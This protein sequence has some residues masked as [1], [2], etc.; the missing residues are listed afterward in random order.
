MSASVFCPHFF[1]GCVFSSYW[2]IRL[3]WIGLLLCFMNIFYQSMAL[4]LTFLKDLNLVVFKISCVFSFIVGLN[5]ICS[6]C[7]FMLLKNQGNLKNKEMPFNIDTVSTNLNFDLPNCWLWYGEWCFL[8]W[9]KTCK[10][11]QLHWRIF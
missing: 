5:S 1:F 7:L 6:L 4:V 8:Y 10:F 11:M 3:T 9:S 2:F